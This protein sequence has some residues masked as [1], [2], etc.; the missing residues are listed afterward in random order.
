MPVSRALITACTQRILSWVESHTR[1]SLG[2]LIDL[3]FCFRWASMAGAHKKAFVSFMHLYLFHAVPEVNKSL[4]IHLSDN[5]SSEPLLSHWGGERE[6]RKTPSCT[7][8][9]QALD[10]VSALACKDKSKYWLRFLMVGGYLSNTIATSFSALSGKTE[11]HQVLAVGH[12]KCHGSAISQKR[13]GPLMRVLAR[14]GSTW[15]RLAS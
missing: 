13:Q 4:S 6:L 14:A 9:Y 11:G 3:H 8:H 2:D 15:T 10:W 5:I 12:I 7:T 1:D